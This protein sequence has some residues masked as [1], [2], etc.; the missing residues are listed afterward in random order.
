MEER[1]IEALA[2]EAD[3]RMYENKEKHYQSIGDTRK[4]QTGM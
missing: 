1:T 3:R 4:Y 2:K